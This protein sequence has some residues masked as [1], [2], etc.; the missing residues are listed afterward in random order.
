V[1]EEVYCNSDA[2]SNRRVDIIAFHEGTRS[3]FVVDPTVRTESSQDQPE[4]VNTEKQ[5]IYL[6]NECLPNLKE[7]YNLKS[8]EVTGIFVGAKGTIS[9]FFQRFCKD[10]KLPK[11]LLEDVAIIAVMGSHQILTSHLYSQHIR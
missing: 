10:H 11:Q 2:G 3:G 7:K 1:Y 6:Y 9:K 4:D 8:L 5:G